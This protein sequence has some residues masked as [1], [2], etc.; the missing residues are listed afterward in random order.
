MASLIL[1]IS[2]LIGL[3]VVSLIIYR[4][5]PSYVAEK[6]KNLASKEDL[7]HLTELVESVKSA[8]MSEIERVKAALLSEGHAT[9]RRRHIYEDICAA[10]RIFIAGHEST[11]IAKERFHEAYAAAW[12]WASDDVLGALNNFIKLQTQHDVIRS[13]INQAAAKDAYI[14]VILA[15]RKDVGFPDATIKASDYQFVYIG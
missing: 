7:A 2:N 13:P 11:P 4:Y 12:L 6:G 8:H 9:E 15:M 1:S 5:L 3:V 14:A 10:L